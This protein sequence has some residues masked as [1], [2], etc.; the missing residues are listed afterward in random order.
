M[1]TVIFKHTLAALMYICSS[2][3]SASL[4]SGCLATNVL[5]FQFVGRAF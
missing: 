5:W 4:L 2:F 1:G 3:I